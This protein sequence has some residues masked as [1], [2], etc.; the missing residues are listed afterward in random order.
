MRRRPRGR[1]AQ[2]AGLQRL[3]D[4][5]RHMAQIVLAGPLVERALAH[6]VH[7]QRRVA[8]IHAV[9]DPLRQTL[10]GR[11]VFGEGLP[12][13][14]DARP[15]SP[16]SGCPRPRSG[17]ARTILGPAGLHGASAKPQLPITTLVTPCQHEQLPSGSQA[18]CAS[19]CVWPSIKPGVTISPSASTIRSAAAWMRPISTIRPPRTPTSAR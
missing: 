19:I 10:D 16:R 17:S 13:P 1:E 5:M 18:T 3:V 15:S 8:D 9:I 4:R 6:R 11:Q 7:A 2:R 12:G 14:V